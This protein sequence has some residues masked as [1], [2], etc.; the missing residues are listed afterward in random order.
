M[1]GKVGK[2][3]REGGRNDSDSSKSRYETST[4][5]DQTGYEK[6]KLIIKV[7]TK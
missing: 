7:D 1:K 4:G 2:T 6:I 3:T 5:S